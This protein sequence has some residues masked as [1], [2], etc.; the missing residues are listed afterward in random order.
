MIPIHARLILPALVAVLLC[1]PQASAHAQPGATAADDPLASPRWPE[2]RRVWF[3]DAPL[4]FDPRIRVRAP[5]I[6]EDPLK[7]PV[8]VDARALHAELGVAVTDILILAD[9]NPIVRALH[10][11]PGAAVPALGFALKLQQSSPVRAAV[12]T[13]D[14]V[15]HVGGT[16]VT[17]TGGGCTL[18]S[19]GSGA[20]AWQ[21]RL[22]HAEA[23]AWPR[24]DGG[25]R[26][27]LHIV[28]PMD[29]GLAAGIPAFH[30]EEI[31]LFAD[32]GAEAIATL[33]PFEPVAENPLFTLDLPP[34]LAVRRIAGRDNNGN[35]I[36]AEVGR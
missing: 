9:F 20:A 2:L 4:R 5:A 3:G 22:N 21:Q 1:A 25:E 36:A 18:P 14:G 13:A 17:T 28:H 24:V 16:Q 19:A 35:R 29:T 12:R 32:D 8:H 7:V 30:V 6:A 33:Q 23:R 31:A 11:A 26:L 34:G 15:W 10:Y 27:K